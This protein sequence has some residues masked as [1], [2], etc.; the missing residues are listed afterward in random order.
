MRL[1]GMGVG[2]EQV[3]GCIQRDFI[4]MKHYNIQEN[5][6]IHTYTDIYKCC[7]SI[8]PCEKM[9]NTKIKV[10][11]TSIC[12]TNYDRMRRGEH[13]CRGLQEGHNRKY[14]YFF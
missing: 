2:R 5:T 6:Q 12:N 3:A 11:G 9:I 10:A 4:S 13:G 14:F 7:K 8:Q 1:S